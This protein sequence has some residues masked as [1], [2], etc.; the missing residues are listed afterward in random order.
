GW[1][2]KQIYNQENEEAIRVGGKA[3]QKDPVH[4]VDGLSGATLTTNG[5]DD[6]ITFW[7]GENG[8]KP[9]LTRLK[10]NGGKING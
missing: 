8:F 10:E 6:L 3:D 1:Q 9:F 2:D 5:V 4:H 7:F